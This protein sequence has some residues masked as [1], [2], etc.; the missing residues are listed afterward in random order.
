MKWSVVWLAIAC[1]AVAGCSRQEANWRAAAEADTVAAY[2]GYLQRFPAGAHVAEARAQ[3]GRLVDDDQWARAR[4]LGTPEALQRYLSAHPEG[5]HAAD[6]HGRLTALVPAAGT[7]RNW[8]A[9]LGAYSTE[10]SAQADMVRIARA[11]GPLFHGLKWRILEPSAAA[12][13]R[14]RAGPLDEQGARQ[15]CAEL[16]AQGV[17]CV[18]VAE[19]ISP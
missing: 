13:W 7:P 15:L 2:E 9:Q 4:N 12:L 18:P 11:Q 3:I 19:P 16:A 8:S 1:L 5:R 10:A 14:L 17:S 6:A